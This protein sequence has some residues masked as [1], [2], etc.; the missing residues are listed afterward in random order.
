MMRKKA[1]TLFVLTN[2]YNIQ[3]DYRDVWTKRLEHLS[4]WINKPNRRKNLANLPRARFR[5]LKA[6]TAWKTWQACGSGDFAIWFTKTVTQI[7]KAHPNGTGN[8]RRFV[9]ALV[10]ELMQVG[11]AP[12]RTAERHLKNGDYAYAEL[13]RAWLLTVGL[14]RDRGMI[15]CLVQRALHKKI[16]GE[17]MRSNSGTTARCFPR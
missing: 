16:K 15:K 2:W 7:A 12:Q 3:E 1:L 10:L 6:P 9:A 4:T 14:R 13:K 11:K 5:N 17:N 8:L